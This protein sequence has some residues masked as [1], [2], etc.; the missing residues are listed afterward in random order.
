LGGACVYGIKKGRNVGFFIGGL[1]FSLYLNYG[2]AI[3]YLI[4]LVKDGDVSPGDGLTVRFRMLVY[5]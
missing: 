2:I 4:H 3:W 5:L 1:M